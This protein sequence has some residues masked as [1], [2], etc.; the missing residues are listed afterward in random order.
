MTDTYTP[1]VLHPSFKQPSPYIYNF[2]CANL[3]RKLVPSLCYSWSTPN[4]LYS[5]VSSPLSVSFFLTSEPL[6]L[7]FGPALRPV[8]PLLVHIWVMSLDSQEHPW[9]DDPGA[10]KIPY[11]L[12]SSEKATFAGFLIGAILYGAHEKSSPRCPSNRTRFVCSV[13]SRGIDC[14]VLPMYGRTI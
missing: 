3:N 6:L 11:Y 1:T 13:Y 2:S 12:Y 9:S 7:R 4:A 14:T 5:P 8:P 10:P